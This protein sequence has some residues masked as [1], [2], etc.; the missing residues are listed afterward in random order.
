ML[1]CRSLGLRGESREVKRSSLIML[2]HLLL[3]FGSTIGDY[4]T[5]LLDLLS[6]MCLLLANMSISGD[7]S[8]RFWLINSALTLNS[9][10]A[11]LSGHLSKCLVKLQ[12]KGDSRAW[13]HSKLQ[14]PAVFLPIAWERM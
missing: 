4:L 5:L 2:L 14:I 12:G 10:L 11:Y 13:P 1:L 9:T 3:I 7:S 6:T 8:L